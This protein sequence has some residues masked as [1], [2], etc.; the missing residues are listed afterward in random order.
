MRTVHKSGK[1]NCSYLHC[2]HT[3]FISVL[4][5]SQIL[6]TGP[7]RCPLPTA[8]AQRER[9]PFHSHEHTMGCSSQQMAHS[10]LIFHRLSNG[11]VPSRVLRAFS[12]TRLFA[13][14]SNCQEAPGPACQS[15]AD[16]LK[17]S[18]CNIAQGCLVVYTLGGHCPRTEPSGEL[19]WIIL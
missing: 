9:W 16:G 13:L 7:L 4:K 17:P 3:S 15:Q 2:Q 8:S 5:T 12:L 6:H 10:S 1:T 18:H 19:N 11:L 14:A